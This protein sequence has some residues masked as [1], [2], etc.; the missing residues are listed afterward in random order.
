MR[1][2]RIA[3]KVLQPHRSIRMAIEE[4][5]TVQELAQILKVRPR[6]VYDQV[7]AGKL[8]SIPVGGYVRF[9]WSDVEAHLMA[10]AKPA[11]PVAVPDEPAEPS[12]RFTTRS[13]PGSQPHRARRRSA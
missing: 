9:R 4:F 13:R 11:R 8:P 1:Q 7:E 5:L 2:E 10:S 12:S 6:W 3:P